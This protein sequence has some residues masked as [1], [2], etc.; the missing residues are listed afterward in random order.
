MNNV[1]LNQVRPPILSAMLWLLLLAAVFSAQ[2]QQRWY[3][4]RLIVETGPAPRW[5][6]RISP[7]PLAAPTT[8]Q[9][10]QGEMFLLVD[11]QANVETDEVYHHYARAILSE[12]GLHQGGHLQLDF[13]PHYQKLVLHEIKVVRG[14][15]PANQ[16]SM[17]DMKLIQPGQDMEHHL[18]DGRLLAVFF[19][20][21]VRAGDTVEY[22]YTVQ[23]S[24]LLWDKRFVTA[25]PLRWRQPVQHQ[26]LKIHCPKMR[27][28]NVKKHGAAHEPQVRETLFA[29]DFLWE[30][31]S[32]PALAPES[33]LPVWCDPTPFA[34]VSEF[35]GWADV[36]RWAHGLFTAREP[37]SLELSRQVLQ[38]QQA[39]ATQEARVLAALRFVQDQVRYLGFEEAEHT[40]QP[41]K[42]SEVI[43][44]RFGDCKDKAVLFCAM[45]QRMSVE[46]DPV[47]VHSRRRHTI[48]Q[49]HPS[50]HAFDHVI[51][52]VNLRGQ[53]LWVDPTQSNQRG[54]LRDGFLP[55][56]GRG[57]VVRADT[58]ALT[59]I[60]F[61]RAGWP[62]MDVH[63][64]FTF[65]SLSEPALL[66][67]VT[68]LSGDEAGRARAKLADAGSRELEKRYVNHYA[69]RF[70]QIKPTQ[71]VKVTDDAAANCIE[72]IEEYEIADFFSTDPERR[73]LQ[74][75]LSPWSI[76][77]IIRK[78]GTAARAQPLGVPH[79]SLRF[80]TIEL[81]LPE[82]WDVEPEDI[83]VEDPAFQF[84]CRRTSTNHVVRLAYEFETRADAVPA[85]A[86]G[87]YARHVDRVVDALSHEFRRD[88]TPKPVAAAEPPPP[89]PPAPPPPPVV[90]ERLVEQQQDKAGDADR[91]LTW[92]VITVAAAACLLIL[93]R[94]KAGFRKTTP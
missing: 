72:F 90:V 2:A 48:E 76:V 15:Q 46:A 71:P 7:R 6:E 82:S 52:R 94:R 81:R 37:P 80:H 58:T 39:H 25:F 84:R 24:N 11:E 78:P 61:P 13:D 83:L 55:D 26:R 33:D 45:L 19:L 74:C 64:V 10:R 89:A 44:R 8:G 73:R 60:P 68:R 18:Y 85:G 23:G 4:N 14:G 69:R 16:L 62:R 50:P 29:R 17:D 41:A 31:E 35:S 59:A 67:T 47:L 87:K 57:L 42:P 75:E 79:P 1:S 38:W 49:W 54:G 21:D 12:A 32:L 53:P 66:R 5:I 28:L 77:E 40:H 51:V 56:Y 3:R 9:L 34:Q 91:T 92:A 36:A 22:A 63:E 88:R 93:L 27:R 43:A 70:L 86:I 20:K 65:K 30:A